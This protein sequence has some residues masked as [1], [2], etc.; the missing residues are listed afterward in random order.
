[1]LFIFKLEIINCNILSGNSLNKKIF[2]KTSLILVWCS[3]EIFWG[4]I[5]TLL[6]L[7]FNPLSTLFF[8]LAWLSTFSWWLLNLRKSL[9]FVW[10]F[11]IPN[12]LVVCSFSCKQ[13]I[14]CLSNSSSIMSLLPIGFWLIDLFKGLLLCLTNFFNLFNFILIFLFKSGRSSSLMSTFCM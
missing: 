14:I 9:F 2:L 1:M 3:F 5:T 8:S 11:L 10:L 12:C 7:L 4:I 13:K 6:G